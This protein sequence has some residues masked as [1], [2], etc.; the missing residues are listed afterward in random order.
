MNS[1]IEEIFANNNILS[2][3]KLSD[4]FYEFTKK[5]FIPYDINSKETNE[6]EL[7]LLY[8]TINIFSNLYNYEASMKN[9]YIEL[10]N[11]INKQSKT[12]LRK[13]INEFDLYIN[14]KN[15]ILDVYKNESWEFKKNYEID[16]RKTHIFSYSKESKISFNPNQIVNLQYYFIN[17]IKLYNTYFKV[18][19]RLRTLLNTNEK[20]DNNLLLSYFNKNNTKR[21]LDIEIE[22]NSKLQELNKKQFKAEF[23]KILQYTFGVSNPNFYFCYDNL[24]VNLKTNM[25]NILDLLKLDYKDCLITKKIDG[26]HV[27]FYIKNKMCYIIKYNIIL[28]LNCNILKDYEVSGAGELVYIKGKR[29]LI[30]FHIDKIIEKNKV[31]NYQTKLDFLTVLEKII[32][33]TS[34]NNLEQKETVEFNEI[35]DII[36]LTKK[37]YG[38]YQTQKEFLNN[39][40][41]CINKVDIYPEDGIIITKNTE[42]N[43]EKLIDYKFKLINTIDLY[44]NLNIYKP[45][46][47]N[48]LRF[49]LSFIGIQKNKKEKQ[50]YDLYSV[51]I[52]IT[53]NFY[54]DYNLSMIIYTQNNFKMVLPLVF[55]SEYYID[56]NYFKPRLDKT[57]KLYKKNKY[58][59]NGLEVILKCRVIHLYK[60]Y[61]D[62]NTLKNIFNQTNLD[63]F[64][65]T[66]ETKIK[67]YT[68]KESKAIFN[69]SEKNDGIEEE[70][71]EDNNPK[72][73]LVEPL[74]FNKTWY[75][76]N[77]NNENR[78]SLNILTNLNKT[79]GLLFG[80]GNIINKQNYKTLVSI[81]CGKGGDLGK[82]V[83]NDISEVLGI[84]PN[85][86]VLKIFEERRKTI[87]KERVKIFN[88]TTIALHLE[89]L[90]FIEKVHK[91]IGMNKTFD[92][93]DI[94]LGIHFSLNKVT[95]DHIMK[96]LYAFVNKNKEPKTRVLISTNDKDNII[97]LHEY[98][99]VPIGEQLNINFDK[100]YVYQITCKPKNKVEIFY[101]PSMNEP[102][103]EY[104]MS[105]KYL[106]KLFEKHNYSLINTWSFDE[107][108]QEQE[109]FNQLYQ[110]YKR[111]STKL[112]LMNIK[113]IDL[114][115]E[116][117]INIMKIFRY[118]IFEYNTK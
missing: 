13:N 1:N 102:N 10:K 112:F 58:Y 110:H 34:F 37:F 72:K 16:I 82:F 76:P 75:K 95:E 99:K 27:Q 118:Y 104:L 111:N 92:V 68:T 7:I 18:E 38:P 113:D 109:I 81:Y 48:L 50:I 116:N 56:E 25:I 61:Y 35:L 28:E 33:D 26:E 91:K 17:S 78:S 60:L 69:I 32:I 59:G 90:D 67:E 73:F 3:Q 117:L 31:L 36:I 106:I 22:F 46:Q 39:F 63:K 65:E 62:I 107:I 47:N 85:P 71:E 8:P 98:Y 42:I 97:K 49:D 64:I 84:D 108:I 2:I 41:N 9:S 74:N 54:Y 88:L 114:K 93:I 21:T 57:N 19:I 79:Y 70:I 53:N 24:A 4:E 86:D 80:I 12:R 15:N 45:K 101:P 94:Q 105:K 30:P 40:L 44:T 23:I 100:N 103:E 55:I 43:T 51:Y 11:V 83:H 77:N 5:N 14:S 96:I 87:L 89:E 20:T 52:A 6:I 66:L 115:N 29:Y